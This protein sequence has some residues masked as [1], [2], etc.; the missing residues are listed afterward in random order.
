MRSRIDR[1]AFASILTACSVGPI[2]YVGNGLWVGGIRDWAAGGVGGPGHRRFARTT[3]IMRPARI[4]AATRIARRFRSM[5][6][7][8]SLLRRARPLGR[9]NCRSERTAIAFPDGAELLSPPS[10]GQDLCLD[11]S[12][13]VME[14]L[15]GVHVPTPRE[16]FKIR[17]VH[18]S[19]ALRRDPLPGIDYSFNPYIGCYHGCLFCYVPRLL[20]IDRNTWGASVVVKRNAATVLAKELRR[21]PRGL[22]A[23]STATD[24]YQF[25]E[26]KY[27]ITRHAL[28]VLL[29]AQWPVSVLSRAPLMIRDLDLFTQFPEIEVGMSVPTLDDRARALLEPWAPPIDARLRCLRA[30]ADAGLTT[31]VGFAPAYPPTG[32]WTPGPIAEAVAEAG[33]KKMFTRALDARWGVA[34]A[35]AKRLDGSDL[36]VDLARIGDPKTIA[37]FV[38]RL[39]EECRARGI[40]FRNAFEFR[41]AGSNQ[42][43]DRRERLL[44]ADSSSSDAANY[45]RR[46]RFPRAGDATMPSPQ[47]PRSLTIA[48]GEIDASDKTTSLL[49]PSRE[50]AP[51]L[52]FE[53]FAETMTTSRTK[54]GRHG[55]QAEEVVIY[56]VDGEV[57]HVDDSGRR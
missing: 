19:S 40:D 45:I 12:R 43:S 31:F 21:L 37:P 27:R 13:A 55:H 50:Q 24:P 56:L 6:A 17:E 39:A 9:W 54:L 42:A 20:Q 1:F 26:G 57:D 4:A 7:T 22:V 53:R 38:S 34:E 16:S 18:V 3:R 5:L 36:A 30:L 49:F 23:I 28:E 32:G 8:M 11:P 33:V 51:W 29:R 35:M 25:V 41:M 52:P 48:H 44:G 2:G 15:L 46:R 14:E 47:K 10:P